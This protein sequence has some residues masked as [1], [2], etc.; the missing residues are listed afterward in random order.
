[1]IIKAWEREALTGTWELT[2]KIDGVRA[3]LTPQ[4]A[5][6]RA[7]KPL[8]N[9]NRFL[10]AEG[11]LDVEVYLGSFDKTLTAVRSYKPV[12]ISKE[13]LYSLDLL[14]HVYSLNFVMTL[15]LGQSNTTLRRY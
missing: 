6:S 9:L 5:V 13:N 8:H 14:I 1:M 15:S 10:P 11:Q 12:F 4:G 2:R 7:G 3:F